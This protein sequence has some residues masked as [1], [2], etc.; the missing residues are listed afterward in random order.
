MGHRS[1]AAFCV[2]AVV[3]STYRHVVLT[4]PRSLPP[5]SFCCSASACGCVHVVIVRS[6]SRSCGHDDTSSNR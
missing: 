5:P 1:E 6:A 4:E 2:R 3:A